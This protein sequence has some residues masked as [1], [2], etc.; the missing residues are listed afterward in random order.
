MARWALVLAAVYGVSWLLWQARSALT[1]FI[2]GLVLAY[3]FLPFVNRLERRM[4]RWAAIVIVYVAVLALVITFFAFLVPPLTEQLG[5]LIRAL[6]DIPTV[7]GWVNALIKQYDLLIAN[8]PAAMRAQVQNAVSS[9]VSQAANTLRTNFVTYLQGIGTFLLDSFLS[10]ANTVSFLLGF[11]LIPFWLFYV[12]MDQKAGRDMIDRTLPHWL[13]AD[14]W[15]VVTIVDYDFSGYLRGQLLLGLVVGS[16][17]G[18]GLAI[19]NMLGLHIPYVLLLAVIAGVTELI[20]IIGPILG[21]IPA[22]I[23]GFIDSPTTGLAVVV[24]YVAIQQLENNF[25]VPRIVGDSVGLHPALLMLLLVVCSTVFGVIGAILSAP[26]GAVS[27]DVFAYLYGRLSEPPRPA[28]QMPPRLRREGKIRP[29]EADPDY[30]PP[31]APW[32]TPDDIAAPLPPS[33]PAAPLADPVAPAPKRQG[34]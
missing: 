12:L 22:I 32:A 7:Q 18:I 34:G 30:E 8:L 2:F 27:R 5:Q 21:S 11:F 1:P 25:L 24:L 9:I 19:L 29:P 15:S 14:F 26:L 20:P 10:V 28:G 33:E 13:R 3:L 6:P 16:S 17:A 31:P 4:P 23:L